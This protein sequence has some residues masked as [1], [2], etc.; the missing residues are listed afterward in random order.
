MSN[1]EVGPP[2]AEPGGPDAID[3]AALATS[4]GRRRQCIAQHFTRGWI[5]TRARSDV[6]Y[7]TQ[8]YPY[9]NCPAGWGWDKLLTP[10]PRKAGSGKPVNDGRLTGDGRPTIERLIMTTPNLHPTTEDTAAPEPTTNGQVKS[11]RFNTHQMREAA[12][13]YSA[14]GGSRAR[15]I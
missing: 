14:E 3:A 2:A 12:K 11:K 8:D 6:A 13:L 7:V 10:K 5:E 4:R 1:E 15:R 9:C